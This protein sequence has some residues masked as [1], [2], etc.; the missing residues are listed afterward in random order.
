MRTRPKLQPRVEARLRIR[1]SHAHIQMTRELG[2]NPRK[3][4]ALANVQQDPWK[5]SLAGSIAKCHRNAL[6]SCALT[7]SL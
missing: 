6:W 5:R 7:I 3:R 1:P 4:V 2:L